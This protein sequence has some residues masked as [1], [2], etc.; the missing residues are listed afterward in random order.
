[1][2][3]TV[4][5]ATYNGEL[6]LAEQLD[7]ILKQSLS[8]L[9]IIIIDDGSTDGT[10]ALLRQYEQLDDRI[11]V[12]FNSENLGCSRSFE[13]GCE[14]ASG[15]YVA[16]VDQDDRWLAHKLER[17]VEVLQANQWDLVYSACRH[18]NAEGALL[19]TSHRDDAAISGLD[20]TADAFE[21]IAS[22]NSFVLGCSILMTREALQRC[23]PFEHTRFNHDRW[24]ISNVAAWGC[25]GYL[26]EVLFHYRLHGKQ[27]SMRF[28][29]GSGWKGLFQRDFKPLVPFY[30]DE[31]M[32]R[33]L[34]HVPA[35]DARYS[36]YR[37]LADD[38]AQCRRGG[39]FSRLGFV[40]RYGRYLYLIQRPRQRVTSALK[41]A[42]FWRGA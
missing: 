31:G 12:H 41:L 24:L 36:T 27:Y 20:S 17:L 18:M 29:A 26:D 39:V 16:L 5:M 25:V 8:A 22:L 42:L 28:R 4:V 9:E 19:T 23:L 7:S 13:R 34:S 14:M 15:R 33:I 21:V 32:Q 3:V 35:D 37:Q 40:L 2:M 11:Q 30:S 1:M 10:R 6:Y 38:I